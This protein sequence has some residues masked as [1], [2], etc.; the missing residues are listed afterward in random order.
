VLEWFNYE[1]PF[2]QKHYNSS[3]MQSLQKAATADGVVWLTIVSSAPGHA[4]YLKPDEAAAKEKELGMHSTALLG[5]ADGTVGHLY[6]ARTT[7]DMFVINSDGV[8]V[9]S[10]AIDD[11][12]DPDPAT[13]QGATNYVKNALAAVKAGTPVK[14]DET[15][16]YGCGVKY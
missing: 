9:Y 15:R 12:P 2:V 8:L 11:R 10:G 6:E 13:L 7:P 16:S 5:D 14:P 1:C 4:G 3:S